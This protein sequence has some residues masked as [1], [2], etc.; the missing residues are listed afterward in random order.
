MSPNCFDVWEG[1][2]CGPCTGSV[3]SPGSRKAGGGSV[4]SECKH[5]LDRQGRGCVKARVKGKIFQ[6]EMVG[7]ITQGSH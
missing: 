2:E 3:I 4:A 6:I 1:P 7:W 5:G